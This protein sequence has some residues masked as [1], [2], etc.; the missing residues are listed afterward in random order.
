MT[1]HF[2]SYLTILSVA[3]YLSSCEKE[4][5]LSNYTDKVTCNE[6]DDT[7]NTYS[8][9]ISTILNDNCATSGCH[10]ATTHAKGKN[11]SDY[12]NAKN[13]FDAEALCTIYQEGSCTP[14]PR[15][16]SKLS[17]ADIH[18]LTCWA[19]NNYPQ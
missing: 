17:D 10:N 9:K 2:F 15:G 16:A 8:G 11:Y 13:N 4:K 6:A 19:K 7:L 12:A 18:D 14:M 3:I 5:S 1:K